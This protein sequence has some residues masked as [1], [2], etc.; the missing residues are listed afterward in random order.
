M[1]GVAF[2]PQWQAAAAPA[3]WVMGG[4]KLSSRSFV[5]EAARTSFLNRMEV[6]LQS[7]GLQAKDD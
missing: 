4:Y 5:C 1:D 2:V 3:F 7:H 6:V